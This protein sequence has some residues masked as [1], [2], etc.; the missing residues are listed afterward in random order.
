M[1]GVVEVPLSRNKEV[2]FVCEQFTQGFASLALPKG[3]L[4]IFA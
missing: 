2:V 4:W 1:T 3:K